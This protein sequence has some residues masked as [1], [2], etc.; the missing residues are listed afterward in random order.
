MENKIICPEREQSVMFYSD[1]NTDFSSALV[2]YLRIDFGRGEEFWTTWH[3]NSY[4][5]NDSEF[6][7]ELDDAING[8]REKGLLKNRSEMEKFC[9]DK[10]SLPLGESHGFSVE[11]DHHTLFLRCLPRAG[12]YDCYCYCYNT[13]ELQLIQ[14]QN[15]TAAAAPK[16]SL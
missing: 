5:L 3:E 15:Q 16:L 8:L 9:R 1:S 13:Q 14:A 7:Q 10:I 4:S 2:G 11:T 6:R 12:E